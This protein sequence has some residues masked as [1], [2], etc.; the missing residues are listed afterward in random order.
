MHRRSGVN[1]PTNSSLRSLFAGIRRVVFVSLVLVTPAAAQSTVDVTARV[2]FYGDNTEFSNPFREGETLLG[3]FASVFVDARLS[4]RLVLRG[5]AFGNQRFGSDDSFDE[6]RPVIALIVGSKQS[7]LILGTLDTFRRVRAATEPGPDRTGPHGLLPPMQRETLAFERPWEAGMQWVLDVPRLRQ[8]A[9]VNWQRMN[10]AEQREIF[11]AGLTSR[12]PLRDALTL[13][14]DV[15][16]VHQGG[17]LSASAAGPVAD[18]VAAALGVEAAGDV[19]PLDR[20]SL[21]GY[22]LVSRHVPDRERDDDARTG[23]GTFIRAAVEERGWRAHLIL[24]RASDYIKAE[25]DPLYQ[26]LRRDGTRMRGLRDYAEAGLTRTFRLAPASFLE[27][28]A[29]WHRVENDYEY[30]FR[31]LAVAELTKRLK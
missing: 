29:R 17:Q 25:G 21:E 7:H 10:T 30:S 9:W 14:G 11:D 6:A 27:A 12:I 3:T 1:L 26:T 15:H 13:R 16:L 5:G 24:W 23:F 18:S 8:E 22:A 28:S 2:T 31:V 4:E 19:P 20:L